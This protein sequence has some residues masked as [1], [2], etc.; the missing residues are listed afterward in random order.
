[1]HNSKPSAAD[2]HQEDSASNGIKEETSHPTL[3]ID[4]VE[5]KARG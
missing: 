3:N 1:M 2:D 5:Q 4:M